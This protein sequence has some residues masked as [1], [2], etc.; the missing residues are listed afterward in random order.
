MPRTSA[1]FLGPSKWLSSDVRCRPRTARSRY[2]ASMRTTTDNTNIG[3]R[4]KTKAREQGH[5]KT[6]RR[7]ALIE[8]L[9]EE[10]VLPASYYAS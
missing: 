6:T 5:R 4:A 9:I 3:A 1:A 7:K 10:H 2:V 8:G